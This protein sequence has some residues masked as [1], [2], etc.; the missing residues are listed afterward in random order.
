[1]IWFTMSEAMQLHII[2]QGHVFSLC[3]LLCNEGIRAAF[4]IFFKGGQNGFS[5]VPGIGKLIRQS[6][7]INLKG[8]GGANIQQGEANAPPLNAALGIMFLYFLTAHI[9]T[10]TLRDG[11]MHS[12]TGIPASSCDT[13][14]ILTTSSAS[15]SPS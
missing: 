1:M 14:L 2:I 8:R 6:H 15:R 9:A 11:A 10:E 3:K 13:K 12:L 4:R 5:G 7:T